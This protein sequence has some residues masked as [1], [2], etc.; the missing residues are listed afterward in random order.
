VSAC[1]DGNGG[2]DTAQDGCCAACAVLTYEKCKGAQ[3][4]VLEEIC[5]INKPG[6]SACCASATSELAACETGAK[7]D[8][9]PSTQHNP[10]MVTSATTGSGA[11]GSGA[12]GSGV[13]ASGVGG[14]DS[15][16]GGA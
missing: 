5:G 10:E 2:L 7:V 9:D 14:A 12:G 15:G 11:G 3:I 13:G 1:D 8:C 4:D 6:D 16:S